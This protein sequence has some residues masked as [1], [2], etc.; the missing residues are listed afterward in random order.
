MSSDPQRLETRAA[1]DSWVAH[2]AKMREIAKAKPPN[3]SS[4]ALTMLAE[5]AVLCSSLSSSL[6]QEREARFYAESTAKIAK[7]EIV[8]LR[9]QL[10]ELA[11]KRPDQE[12]L[13]VLTKRLR[14]SE[15]TISD[16]RSQIAG[17]QSSWDQQKIEQRVRADHKV[18]SAEIFLQETLLKCAQLE[19][20][21]KQIT[22]KSTEQA[23]DLKERLRQVES[24]SAKELERLTERASML[25][26]SLD[27]EKARC[28]RLTEKLRLEK[29][30]GKNDREL[31][32]QKFAELQGALRDAEIHK[33][34]SSAAERPKAHRVSPKTE[35]NLYQHR[36]KDSEQVE[37][38]PQPRG[39]WPPFGFRFFPAFVFLTNLFGSGSL[40][41]KDGSNFQNPLTKKKLKPL[42][43]NQQNTCLHDPFFFKRRHAHRPFRTCALKFHG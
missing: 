39:I 31:A 40:C 29:T 8:A 11:R 25:E 27:R 9:A 13:I 3:S 26:V 1:V 38:F 14:E 15:Q 37:H 42:L 20:R 22:S 7:D 2:A 28:N 24:W 10:E 41:S 19:E 17:Y 36:S 43:S 18:E 12:E 33:T 23:K 21:C 5:S 16:L 4:A 34:I 32:E 35:E 6:E 30:R